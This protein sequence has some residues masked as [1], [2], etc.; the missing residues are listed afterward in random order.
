MNEILAQSGIKPTDIDIRCTANAI[1]GWMKDYSDKVNIELKQELEK[2][3]RIVE[4]I[5]NKR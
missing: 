4:A 5:I 1:K 3:K 2:Q